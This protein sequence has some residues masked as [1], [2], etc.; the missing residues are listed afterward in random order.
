M[1]DR[2]PMGWSKFD[3][4]GGKFDL[5]HEKTRHDDARPVYRPPR[6]FTAGER[7]LI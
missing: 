4:I 2:N 7:L 1:A 6:H 3:I 5:A